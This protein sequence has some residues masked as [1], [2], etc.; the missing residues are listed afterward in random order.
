MIPQRI[1][2]YWITTRTQSLCPDEISLDCG[3]INDSKTETKTDVIATKLYSMVEFVVVDGEVY[4]DQEDFI[5]ER[6]DW[7]I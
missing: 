1:I 5:I 7:N 6:M 4:W 3:M 2:I